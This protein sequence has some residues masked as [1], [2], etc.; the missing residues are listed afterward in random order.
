MKI[1]ELLEQGSPSAP[2]LGKPATFGQG[3][4]QSFKQG[5]G[6]NPEKSLAAGIAAKALGAAGMKSTAAGMQTDPTQQD[7]PPD[8][9]QSQ[10]AQSQQTSAI[11]PILPGTVFK[12]P[13]F[14]SV[15]VLPNAPGQKGVHLDTKHLFGF[16][17]YLDP[18]ELQAK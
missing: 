14:G 13:K 7:V 1:S 10:T 15:K 18:K 2:T 6:M 16:N 12:D 17:V 5:M 4:K 11:K 3:L 8:Q 9:Q